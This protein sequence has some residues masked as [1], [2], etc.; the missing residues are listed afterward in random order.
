MRIVAISLIGMFWAGLLI[1]CTPQQPSN[2]SPVAAIEAS[3]TSGEAPLTVVLSGA[4]SYDPDG[5]ITRYEWDL[6]NGDKSSG[7]SVTHIY[8]QSATFTVGLSVTDDKGATASA[9]ISITVAKASCPRDST[10]NGQLR[11][12]VRSISVASELGIW[13]P[14]EGNR[15]LI[16]DVSIESLA[17]DQLANALLFKIEEEDGT[18]HDISIATA[19]L[20]KPFESVTLDRGQKT[21]GQ[22]AFEVGLS[23]RQ[24]KLHYKPLLTGQKMKLC[25]SVP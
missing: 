9:T 8:Q 5:T 23:V 17:D 4:R 1:S 12:A 22:L 11:L 24:V 3:V 2:Q 19:S 6:G 20:P 18:A 13:Q 21:G 16:V 15:F 10:S 7:V 14:S 25:L